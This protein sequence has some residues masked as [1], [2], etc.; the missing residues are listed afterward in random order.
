MPLA[1]GCAVHMASWDLHNLALGV[2]TVESHFGLSPQAVVR[3]GISSAAGGTLC[4]I[5]AHG[6]SK[7]LN[8][9]NDDGMGLFILHQNP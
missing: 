9:I 4:L 5:T 1:G 7:R 3:S 6:T 8:E 2:P